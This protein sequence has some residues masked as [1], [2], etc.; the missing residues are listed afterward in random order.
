MTL[1]TKKEIQAWLKKEYVEND[2]YIIHDD[3]SIDLLADFHLVNDY[4][5]LP[6]VF[7][8]AKGD[9]FTN[10]S[11]LTSLKGFPLHVEKSLDISGNALVS[12]EF[13]PQT[14]GGYFSASHN[15]LESLRFFPQSVKGDIRLNNNSLT[16][17]SYLPSEVNGN[18]SLQYNELTSLK[19]CPQKLKNLDCS[20]NQL[21]SLE[22]VS[23]E[24]KEL[25]MHANHITS[26]KHLGVVHSIQANDNKIN[27]FSYIPESLKYLYIK[28]NNHGEI[29]YL[30][31]S[32]EEL[33]KFKL[34][35]RLL[36]N[37]DEK[38]IKMRKK[39]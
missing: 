2:A 10:D 17:L 16:H 28:Q 14:V 30:S 25:T 34:H 26:L 20:H 35:H 5:V 7:N 9:F 33:E 39:V 11:G 8:L 22:G 12:L 31:L 1:K 13:C 37:M 18:L 27:D 24:I 3:L 36:E 6:V 15:E 21:A 38:P 32:D 29:Q 23:Q 4:Q 19:G